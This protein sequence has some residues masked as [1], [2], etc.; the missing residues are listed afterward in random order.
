MVSWLHLCDVHRSS[1]GLPV[2]PKSASSGR[3]VK[4]NREVLGGRGQSRYFHFDP[5]Q[6]VLRAVIVRAPLTRFLA[7]NQRPLVLVGDSEDRVT[8]R[9]NMRTAHHHVRCCHES[10]GLIRPRA[11][12]LAVRHQTTV[13]LPPLRPRTRVI[14]GNRLAIRQRARRLR[15]RTRPRCFVRLRGSPRRH[16]PQCQTT[17]CQNRELLSHFLSPF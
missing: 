3:L 11:P 9:G 15:R 1:R 14:H 4:R 10:S 2:H 16:E 5:R 6:I 8:P 13:N 17:Q 7:D 12:H